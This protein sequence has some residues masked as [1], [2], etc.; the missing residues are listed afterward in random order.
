[1]VLGKRRGGGFSDTFWEDIYRSVVI[2]ELNRFSSYP[3]EPDENRKLNNPYKPTPEMR[4]RCDKGIVELA[5]AT[6]HVARLWIQDFITEFA[7]Q[8]GIPH[9]GSCYH[10]PVIK[11]LEGV[12]NG[13]DGTD[14]VDCLGLFCDMRAIYTKQ[15]WKESTSILGTFDEYVRRI[16]FFSHCCFVKGVSILDLFKSNAT[17][18]KESIYRFYHS[19]NLEYVKTKPLSSC[20]A[21]VWWKYNLYNNE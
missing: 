10:T 5:Y 6:R 13:I 1:M 9:T 16:L 4:I 8:K 3:S 7:P 14:T 20:F 12:L 18:S 2:K 19:Y 17:F 11:E 15:E 21:L